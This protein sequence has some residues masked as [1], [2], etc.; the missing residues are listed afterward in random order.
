MH[1]LFVAPE[2]GL[3]NLR[4]V[5]GLVRAG[6]RVSG[7]GHARR[8]ALKPELAKQLAA[9]RQ[10]KSVLDGAEVLLVARELAKEKAI[11]RVETI[12]E[13]VIECAAFVRKE[14]GLPGLTPEQAKLCRD[15]AAMKDALRAQGLPCAASTAARDRDTVMQFAE[16]EGFPI[17]VKPIAGFGTLDTFKVGSKEELDRAL[18]RLKPSKERALV[19]EEFIEGHEGFYDTVTA[20]GKIAHDFVGHYYPGCLEALSSRAIA[21]QIACTNR[22]EEQSYQELRETAQKVI[23]A[24]GL[25]DCATH[26]EWFF[27]PKGLK[28]SE[29]GARPAGERIWDMHVA[30]NELDL[31]RDWALAVLQGK[32]EGQASR[33]Y[34]VGSVQIRPDRDGRYRGHEGLQETMRAIG[35]ALVES[36]IPAPGSATQPLEKGWHVNTW[37]RVKHTDYDQLRA[38]LDLI[39]RTVRVRAG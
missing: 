5:E 4:F 34:A 9:Y 29:I 28:V 21:P 16:R 22:V 19:V 32:V 35:N 15:K 1:V 20:S 11:E 8:E 6:A 13:P 2:T 33:K 14:L 3:Y 30:G 31:Y 39:G 24:L 17:I 27:G 26:M 25:T 36:E 12:D 18:E 7:V 37:F 38:L 23:T 10:V